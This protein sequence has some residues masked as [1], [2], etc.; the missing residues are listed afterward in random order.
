MTSAVIVQARFASTRLPGKVLLPLGARPELAVVLERCARIPG[1]DVVVC[2]VPDDRA[3]DAVAEVARACGAVVFRGSERDVL[4]RYD[5]AARA[6]GA[7]IVMRVTSDCPL[8]DPALCGAVLAALEDRDTDYACNTMPPL[9]PHGLDCE[10]FRAEHLARAAAWTQRP[11]DRE[12]VTPWLRRNPDLRRVN[13]DG[14]GGGL[15][16]HRWT[17]DHPADYAFFVALWQ[18][19]GERAA[20]A[21]TAEILA[22]L[23]ARP[24]IVDINRAHFDE[25]RLAD[26]SVLADLRIA[27]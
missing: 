12:H 18:A 21:S 20:T 13:C 10:A 24:E 1:I 11:Y 26:R 17:L 25:K 23:S 4:A 3:S 8:I 9:W 14:P 27:A 22:A 19:M 15:E 7:A 2:A 6:V 5:G 16:R